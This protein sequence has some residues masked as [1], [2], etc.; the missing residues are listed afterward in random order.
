MFI[1]KRFASVLASSKK[2]KYHDEILNLL[3]DCVKDRNLLQVNHITPY[4]YRVNISKLALAFP[5]CNFFCPL[6]CYNYYSWSLCCILIKNM[7]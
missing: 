2:S 7:S 1:N 3:L 6:L 5:I 4:G